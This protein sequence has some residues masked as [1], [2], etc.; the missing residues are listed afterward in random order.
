MEKSNLSKYQLLAIQKIQRSQITQ[1]KPKIAVK[2]SFKKIKK[3]ETHFFPATPVQFYG[4][5]RP[6]EALPRSSEL[7]KIL[8][9]ARSPQYQSITFDEYLR[10]QDGRISSNKCE[11]SRRHH[12]TTN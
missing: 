1:I 7:N 6:A 12:Q 5:H 11:V 3:I 2:K 9:K 4:S 8:Q 10:Q